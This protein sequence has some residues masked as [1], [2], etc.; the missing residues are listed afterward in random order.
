M[1]LAFHISSLAVRRQVLKVIRRHV[2]A[3]FDARSRI[4][5]IPDSNGA[6]LAA[7]S[8]HPSIG[9]KGDTPHGFCVTVKDIHQRAVLR[10]PDSNG[11]VEQPRGQFRPVCTEAHTGDVRPVNREN[12]CRVA[13]FQVEYPA[14][15]VAAAIVMRTANRD[16]FAIGTEVEAAE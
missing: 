8:H 10:I 16:L 11:V 1:E 9:S 5:E 4:V 13:G 6:V 12:L 3:R 14:F 2:D 7:G 15:S